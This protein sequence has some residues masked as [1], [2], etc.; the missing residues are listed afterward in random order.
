MKVMQ[1]INEGE[2][3]PRAVGE[4][5]LRLRV[6]VIYEDLETGLRARQTLDHTVRQLAAEADAHVNL[7]RFDL[8]SEPRL[9]QRAAEEAAEADIVFCSAHGQRELPAIV[10]LWLQEWFG[11]KSGKPCALA[12]SLDAH[13]KDTPPATRMMEAIETAARLAGVDVFLHLGEVQT[14]FETA[15]ANIQQRAERRT[16]VVDELLHEAEPRRFRDWGINE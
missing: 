2:G 5:P 4:G 15:A 6:L 9:R 14:E 10:N 1:G 13:A 3:D 12:V 11:N 16:M 7:W 8:L